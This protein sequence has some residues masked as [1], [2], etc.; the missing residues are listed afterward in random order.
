MYIVVPES[1]RDK[2]QYEV[3]VTKVGRRYFTTKSPINP[4]FDLVFE[5]DNFINGAWRGK[6]HSVYSSWRAYTSREVYGKR[7]KKE[8]VLQMLKT[9]SML[10]CPYQEIMALSE[11]L[12]TNLK[13]EDWEK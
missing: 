4:D 5:I 13:F 2:G 9:N 7:Q 1:N 10:A 11:V 12:E 8:Y 3:I 6:S